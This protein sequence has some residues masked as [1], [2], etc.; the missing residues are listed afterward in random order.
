MQLLN[1][2]D[3]GAFLGVSKRT[4]RRLIEQKAFP[5]YRVG[6]LIRIDQKDLE[7]YLNR[8]KMEKLTW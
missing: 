1:L 5:F 2:V 4:V 7:K 6:R 3:V 8:H